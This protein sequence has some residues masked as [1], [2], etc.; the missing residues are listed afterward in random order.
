MA[1]CK[2]KKEKVFLSQQHFESKVPNKFLRALTQQLTVSYGSSST[3]QQWSHP[4]TDLIKGF[5]DKRKC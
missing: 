5:R 2:V 4:T 3:G 1:V